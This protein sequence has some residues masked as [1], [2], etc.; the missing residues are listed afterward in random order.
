MEECETG[1]AEKIGDEAS[2]DMSARDNWCNKLE[3]KFS[4]LRL[5][6]QAEVEDIEDCDPPET[7]KNYTEGIRNTEDGQ[8]SP[9]G[10]ESDHIVVCC[11]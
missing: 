11:G 3:R 7:D 6:K 10:E 9:I 8:H 5:A 2:I 1:P 4:K